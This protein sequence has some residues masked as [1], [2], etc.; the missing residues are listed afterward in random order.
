[1]TLDLLCKFL[2][3]FIFGFGGNDST[4]SKNINKKRVSVSYLW[5]GLDYIVIIKTMRG[6]NKNVFGNFY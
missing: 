2:F 6:V 4:F 3:F 1:M 5:V